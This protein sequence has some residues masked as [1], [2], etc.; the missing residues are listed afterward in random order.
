[1]LLKA[2]VDW[3]RL[4]EKYID[5]G[6]GLAGKIVV[7]F[8]MVIIG[9]KLIKLLIKIIKTTLEKSEIDYGVISFSCSF[10]KIA[11]RAVVI[12][13]AVAHMGIEVSSFVAILGSAGVAVGLALQGS[14]SNIAGGVLLLVLKP[15]QVGDYIVVDGTGCEGVVA[16]M[17]IF[18]TKLKTVDNRVIVIP[19]GTLSNSNLINNT[20]QDRRLIDITVGVSYD[21]DIRKAKEI[22]SDIVEQEKK[23]MDQEGVDIFVSSLDDSAVTLGV[24]CWVPTQEY[25]SAKWRLNEQIKLR[26]DEEGIE[27]PY[28]KLD[29]CIKSEI[30][31]IQE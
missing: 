1:M 19:N 30:D 18:Y 31:S 24:R 27:I 2:N 12:F 13:M 6:L 9:F 28:Q 25:I 16:A 11:L 22:L 8:L 20:N 14:L 26:F 23:I 3:S 7:A 21:T 5:A 17:D 29:V 4:L 10:I 15:F